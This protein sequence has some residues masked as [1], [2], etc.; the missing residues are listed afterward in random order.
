MVKL[1]IYQFQ[2]KHKYLLRKKEVKSHS[3]EVNK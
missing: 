1:P 2:P 3:K